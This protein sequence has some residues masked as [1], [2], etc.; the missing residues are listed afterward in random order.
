MLPEVAVTNT[1]DNIYI[2][3]FGPSTSTVRLAGGEVNLTQT[4]TYPEEGTVEITVTPRKAFEFGISLRIP[5]WSETTMAIVNGE[6][7]GNVRP[8][9]YLDI[10]RRWTP[11]DKI[12]LRLD[13][14]GRL[15]E[16][17][18][19]QAIER[20]PVV[21]ARDSRFGDGYVDETAIVQT[22]DGYVTLLPVDDKPEKMWM[23][24]TAPMVMG[25]DLEGEF[26]Q[27]RQIGLCDFSSAGNTWNK[28]IRYRVWLRKTLNVIF[29]R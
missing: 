11:E 27:P 10:R 25:T 20:G 29:E 3:L 19:C 24:F 2:N 6:S 4:T 9:S 18:G 1:E 12:T 8:G 5:S 15:V 28:N 26:A 16:L 7:I 22:T 14:R 17:D 23:A 21:L 13:M